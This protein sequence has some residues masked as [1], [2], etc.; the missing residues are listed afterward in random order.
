MPRQGSDTGPDSV[1]NH[2][3]MT[4]KDRPLTEPFP[5]RSKTKR[6]CFTA[7]GA[8]WDLA[9]RGLPTS[10]NYRSPTGII[11]TIE[12]VQVE[13]PLSREPL[14]FRPQR[15]EVLQ[16]EARILPFVHSCRLLWSNCFSRD[17]TPAVAGMHGFRDGGN[18]TVRCEETAA[19]NSARVPVD[20]ALYNVRSSCN[21]QSWE[22]EDG[23]P[24][25]PWGPYAFGSHVYK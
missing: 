7:E 18:R 19:G 25:Q 15:R 16:T 12:L 5:E 21:G 8:A 13:D 1:R 20:V 17:Y 6:R 2:D 10:S 23:S 4:Q 24:R 3:G 11:W 22:G 9:P 14:C